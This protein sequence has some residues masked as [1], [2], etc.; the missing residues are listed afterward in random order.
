MRNDMVVSRWGLMDWKIKLLMSPFMDPAVLGWT[1]RTESIFCATGLRF[2]ILFPGNA[3]RHSTPPTVFVVEGSKIWPKCT[4]LPSQGLS[5]GMGCPPDVGFGVVNPGPRI[6]EKS[7]VRSASVG[8][9][10]RM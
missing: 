3:V 4:W 6:A 5:T 10:A 8:R 2:V 1:V 7:P 9:V